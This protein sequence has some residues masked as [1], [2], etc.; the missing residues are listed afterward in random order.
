MAA[1]L[2]A[3]ALLQRAAPGADYL[4]ALVPAVVLSGVLCA[5]GPAMLASALGVAVVA[6]SEWPGLWVWPPGPMALELAM[7]IVAMAAVLAATALPH[8]ARQRAAE[9][10]ARL[11]EVFR[12]LPGAASILSG[13]QGRVFLSSA[14]SEDILGHSIRIRRSA[15]DMEQYGG[16]HADG[17]PYRADEYPI[18]RALR[19]GEVVR[20][21]L[22]RY[23]RPDRTIELEVHAG[24]VRGADG[25]ILGSVG[26]AFDV[27]ERVAAE[28][29]L[30]ESEAAFRA[31]SERLSAALDVG[32]LGL[33]EIDLATRV[34]IWDAR[35]AA[36]LGLP[37]VR[38]ELS[39]EAGRP[40]FAT[41]DQA[42]ALA[43]FERALETGEP[44]ASEFRARTADGQTRWLMMRGLI[45]KAAGRGFGVARDVTEQRL[46]EDEL[47]AAVQAREWLLREA[48]H[49]IKNSLQLVIAMLSLARG[50]LSDPHAAAALTDAIARVH[51]VADA[52]LALQGSGDLRTIDVAAM[53]A[54]LC[55]RLATLNPDVA[56]QCVAD[57][58]INLAADKAIPLGLMVN[59][60]LTNALRHAYAPGASGRISVAVD[61]RDTGLEVTIADDGRGMPSEGARRGLGSRVVASLA[62]QIGAV[63]TRRSAPGEGTSVMFRLTLAEAA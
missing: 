20:G 35:L 21:E 56:L 25:R 14:A 2:I 32:E 1:A 6:A 27:T 52:H 49:R 44:Y 9:A 3:R 48:D 22:L 36:M 60:V 43:D 8:R 41:E 45:S 34:T 24:P 29:R 31:L 19:A 16:I 39:P 62:A 7:F 5:T 47:R 15:D 50:R 13:P 11:A 30:R 55:P 58:P 46:R 42:R 59:E 18:V 63:E 38:V 40:F 10:E 61:R 53:I 37:P 17:R 28:R 4:F 54:D 26:M 33:W 57:G 12:Q 23:R 51:A